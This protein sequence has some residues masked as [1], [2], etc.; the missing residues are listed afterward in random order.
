MWQEVLEGEEEEPPRTGP[1]GVSDSPGDSSEN[2]RVPRVSMDY[3][4]LGGGAK[5]STR[6]STAK[7][8]TH[9]LGAKLKIAMLP[10]MGNR[11]QLIE[12]VR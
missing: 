2:R 11:Q 3:F 8:T 5:S 4:F 9:Q 12:K 10:S 7:M 6:M 1:G